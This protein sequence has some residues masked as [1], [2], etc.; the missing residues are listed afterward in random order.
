[1]TATVPVS[2]S[3]QLSPDRS[4][5]LSAFSVVAFV[6]CLVFGRILGFRSSADHQQV[7]AALVRRNTSRV[8]NL[9]AVLSSPPVWRVPIRAFAKPFSH[10]PAGRHSHAVVVGATA[11]LPIKPADDWKPTG[12]TDPTWHLLGL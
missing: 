4:K 7:R 9:H 11:V 3:A 12:D 10:K 5:P 8:D 1:M 6:R 2:M